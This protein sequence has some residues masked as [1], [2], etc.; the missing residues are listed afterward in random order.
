MIGYGHW[1]KTVAKYIEKNDKFKLLKIYSPSQNNNGFITNDIAEIWNNSEIGIVYIASPGYTHYELTRK[2]LCH[3]KNVICE[4][5]LSINYMESLDIKNVADKNGLFVETNYIY[6]YSDAINKI[7]GLISEIGEIIFCD[8]SIKQLGRFYKESVY[9]VL[10]CHLLAV[11][12][13]LFSTTD[14]NFRK[15]DIILNSIGTVETGA[16]N[17]HRQT[18]HGRI[19]VSLNSIEKERK[20]T[21]YGSEGTIEFNPLS[22]VTVRLI[23]YKREKQIARIYEEKSYSFNENNNLILMIENLE[24]VAL[25]KKQCNLNLAINVTRILDGIL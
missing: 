22:S 11:I 24:A 1:G 8:L 14:M 18:F 25:K 12:D 3:G 21:I 23:K 19:F 13:Y 2:A 10:G 17:F 15:D 20:I 9:E 16:I 6:T 7:R 5:P 4:K